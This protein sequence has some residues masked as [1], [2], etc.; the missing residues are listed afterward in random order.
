MTLTSDLIP[1]SKV[2]VGTSAEYPVT[3]IRGTSKVIGLEDTDTNSYEEITWELEC[4]AEIAEPTSITQLNQTLRSELAKRGLAVILTERGTARQLPASGAGG[5]MVSYPRVEIVDIPEKSRA[6]YQCFNLR[7]TTRIPL[8]DGNGIYEQSTTTEI[9]TNTDG[10]A[11]T[12]VSGSL[13]MDQGNDAADYVQTNIITPARN[14]ASTSGDGVVSRIKT[15]NNTAECEYS[16]TVSPSTTGQQDVTEASVEDRT[17]KDSSGRWI[18]TIS[19]YAEGGNATAFANS[20][21]VAQ[22][23]NLK[24]LSKDGPSTPSLPSGRVSFNY[25]YVSGV[26]HVDFPNIFITRLDESISQGG[27]GRDLIASSYLQSDPALHLGL[28]LPYNL[29]ESLSIEFIGS[30]ADVDPSTH[31]DSE[32]QV[33]GARISKASRGLFNTY[34]RTINYLYAT[35]P[36]PLPD[37]R[38]LGELS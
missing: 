13:K 15:G 7:A 30:F 14:A 35:E 17:V 32:F 38:Q 6:Q 18:R 25:Q 10:T 1:Y 26:T 8:A 27:G 19:G 16:Y 2:K 23:T 28:K 34:S 22:T 12:S 9:T 21:L 3:Q 5:S 20:Q 36:D 37:P 4:L 29:T 24:L 11:V 33:G 31:L